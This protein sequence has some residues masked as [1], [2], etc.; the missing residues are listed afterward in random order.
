[1]DMKA[2]DLL[3]NPNKKRGFAFSFT[4]KMGSGDIFRTAGESRASFENER[5]LRVKVPRLRSLRLHPG[6]SPAELL[7]LIEALRSFQT[8]AACYYRCRIPGNSERGWWSSRLTLVMSSSVTQTPWSK[9]H[10]VTFKVH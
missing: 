8:L 5:T 1:M 7:G 4:H 10:S 2:T 6:L 3:R 9:D